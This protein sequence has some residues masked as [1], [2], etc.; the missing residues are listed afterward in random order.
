MT[1]ISKLNITSVRN[2][3]SCS[4][5]PSPRVNLFFGENGSGKTSV[6]EAIQTLATGRSFRSSKLEPLIKIGTEELTV[7]AELVNGQRA[8]FSKK[9]RGS[10]VVMLDNDR[11]KSWEYVARALPTLVLDASTFQLVDGG[12]KIRRSY[13]DWGVFHVEPTFIVSWRKL[14]RCLSHRNHLLKSKSI[15]REELHAWTA[16]FSSRSNE[17]DQHRQLYLEALLPYFQRVLTNLVPH[18]AAAI[19]LVYHRG[20]DPNEE[21]D[22]LLARSVETDRR[23]GATQSGP[24]RAEISIKLDGLRASD[25]LS[26]GQAKLLVIALKV[27]QGQLLA[28]DSGH[29]CTYLVDDLAS[30]LDSKNR[31]IVLALL[32][33]QKAQLFLTAVNK[34]DILEV[35]DSLLPATFHVER[36]IITA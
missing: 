15:D 26:R 24:H 8:G 21:L 7:Y 31:A 16:E 1:A 17:V 32:I 13:L 23:Y 11:V 10:A 22:L 2:I 28:N 27:A 5:F 18:M 12:P 20:W 30:E 35:I 14:M 25:L 4:V 19:E 9:A 33:E 29:Q 36:G 6:L 3:A 34:S